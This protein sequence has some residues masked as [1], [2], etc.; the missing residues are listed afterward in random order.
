MKLSRTLSFL[1]LFLFAIPAIGQAQ[2]AEIAEEQKKQMEVQ[3]LMQ[4]LMMLGHNSELRKELEVVEGQVDDVKKL[5]QGY[6]KDMMNFYTENRDLIAEMQKSFQEGDMKGGQELSKQY[7]DK[8]REF[9]EG[10]M[11]KVKEVLLPHQINRL[12]QIARQQQT[13]LMNQFND[14]FGVAVS[15]ADELGL[16]AQ[17]K[18]RL[19]DTVK[20]AR[21]EYYET[22]NAAKKKAKDQIFG[23]LTTEQKEKMQ[24]LIGDD[25]DQD[26]MSRK[27]RESSMQEWRTRKKKSKDE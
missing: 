9:M 20:K 10:Y 21:E 16:T 6:Q 7:Q 27:T 4:Q 14:E 8:N 24:E 26:A 11:D 15:L 5:A 3:F 12:K 23:V 22:V 17:E 18:N 1:L 13:K 2:Q 19:I 25:W